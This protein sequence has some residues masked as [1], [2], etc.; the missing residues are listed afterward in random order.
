[1]NLFDKHEAVQH[2]ADLDRKRNATT[3][4]DQHLAR[5]GGKVAQHIREWR[6]WCGDRVWT[7]LDLHNYMRR[8]VQC[9]PASCDRILRDMRKQGELDYR[10]INRR[11]STYQFLNEEQRNASSHTEEKRR[12]RDW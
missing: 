4:Q 3:A 7:T 6:V 2:Q 10:V 11:E 8:R 1:M 5:V 12:N 9:A